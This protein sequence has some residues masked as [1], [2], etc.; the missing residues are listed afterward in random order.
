MVLQPYYPAKNDPLRP[1]RQCDHSMERVDVSH[2]E[3]LPA[4]GQDGINED[5]LNETIDNMLIFDFLDDGSENN[6]VKYSRII[7]PD[8]R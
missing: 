6:Q 5:N 4:L 7:P 2:N 8:I 1:L 3:T